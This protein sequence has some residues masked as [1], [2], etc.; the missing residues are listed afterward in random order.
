MKD[1]KYLE[2]FKYT[3]KSYITIK[4]NEELFCSSFLFISAK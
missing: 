4:N 2:G 3:S 1:N